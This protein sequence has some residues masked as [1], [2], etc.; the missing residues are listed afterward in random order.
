[1]YNIVNCTIHLNIHSMASHG[2]V[3]LVTIKRFW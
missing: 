2:L 1:M 3:M